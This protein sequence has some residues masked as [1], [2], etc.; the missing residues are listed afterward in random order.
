MTETEARQRIAAQLPTDAKLPGADYVINTDGTVCRD[1]R[2]DRVGASMVQERGR[3]NGSDPYPPDAACST[4]PDRYIPT[5]PAPRPAPPSSVF[6]ISIAIV[7]G[8][9][10][11]GTGVSAPATS[12]TSGCTSPTSDR[13]LRR[14]LA[15]A[16][17]R[18]GTALAASAGSVDA[19]M[20]TSITVAPGLTKSRRHEARPADGRHQ[21]VRLA[22]TV[23]QIRASASGRSSPSRRGAAA[24]APSACRRCRCGR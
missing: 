24:A 4:L 6:F 3:S 17:A 21:D 18:P 7:S 2:A 1:R 15:A 5:R 20:P 12:A 8:P 16:D 13:A 11:P 22:G 23:G 14:T 10:P 19:L 9:T